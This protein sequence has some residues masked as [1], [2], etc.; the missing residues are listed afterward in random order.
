[1]NPAAQLKTIKRTMR[2]DGYHNAARRFGPGEWVN[3]Q[4]CT[5]RTVMWSNLLGWYFVPSISWTLLCRA[6]RQAARQ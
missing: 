2:A 1:M 6:V 4:D 5:V 3:P